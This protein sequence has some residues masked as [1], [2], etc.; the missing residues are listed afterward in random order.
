MRGM[1]TDTRHMLRGGVIVAAFA[2]F[3]LLTIALANAQ[4]PPESPT[5]TRLEPGINLVGW[6]GESTSV[7]QL[8]REVPQLEAIWA[9]DAELDDWIVASRDAPEGL[10]WLWRVSP[11]MGLR[12]AVGGEEPFLWERS[13]EPTRGLVELRTGWNLVAW[14]GADDAPLEQVA[15]GIGW[16]LREL[17][18]WNAANQRWTTWTSPER[19]AQL[20]AA[21]AADQGATDEEAEPVTVRRGEALWINVA[22]SVN[23]LQPTDILPRL[24]FPGGASDALQARVQEDLEAV[25]AFYGQ[26]YGIQANPDFAVYVAKDADALI[27]TYK[28]DGEEIDDAEAARIRARW[29][30]VDGWVDRDWDGERY[31]ARIVARRASWVGKSSTS[32]IARARHVLTHEYFHILQWQ[33]T[34]GRDGSE[35]LV[36]GTAE[37]AGSEREVLDGEQTLHTLREREQSKLSSRT[38][39]LR[40]AESD[41]NQW[42]YT[43]GWLAVD[44]LTT[45]AGD[46]S[47]VEFWR[48]SASTEI[49]PHGRWTST[50]DWRTAFQETFGVSVSS[51]YA[52][53]NVWQRQRAGANGSAASSVVGRPRWIR[54]RVTDESGVPAAGV[55]VNAVRVEG[56]IRVG[57]NQRAETDTDGAFAV[58]APEDGDYRLSVDINDDCASRYYYSDGSLLDEWNVYNAHPVKVAGSDLRNI[59][60]QLPPNVCIW[61][62]RGHIT[63][64]AGQPLAGVSVSA[65]ADVYG[66]ND[67]PVCTSGHTAPDGSFA[68]PA[69]AIGENRL[70]LDLTGDCRAYYHTGGVVTTKRGKASPISIIKTDSPRLQIH[71]P[72]GMCAYRINGTIAKSDGQPLTDVSI[73]ACREDAYCVER[74]TDAAGSFTITVPTEGRYRLNFRL[75]GC[76]V[77]LGSGPLTSNRNI[78]W[79]TVEGRDVQLWQRQVPDGWCSQQISGRLVGADGE[80]RARVSVSICQLAGSGC[81]TYRAGTT[82]ADGAFAVTVPVAGEYRLSFE[83]WS[84][85]VCRF[86]FGTNGLTDDQRQRSNVRVDRSGAH[87]GLLEIPAGMCE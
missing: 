60:I 42:E 14:S 43:L 36:E 20:I 61:F 82:D 32:G 48:R 63:T 10:G 28:D 3:L 62:I 24:I 55:F 27:Q 34:G 2:A 19:S 50:P 15:K 53:F 56:D 33:L 85:R 66:P 45:A 40:S 39:T 76:M 72:E 35:W 1:R 52:N 41:N 86:Y 9:W 29:D 80:P 46:G 16:S 37:W 21:S 8:F 65:C 75:D 38:P 13:T 22:R 59:E 7:S 71:V 51:F 57:W 84:I 83:F 78:A 18:R 12:L 79:L 31:I 11:G 49:G 74:D 6:T 30:R 70:H 77:Y 58:R 81:A 87:L 69:A 26:H 47:Y 25:L 54:G 67:S 64:G 5:A 44:R 68:V 4:E 23:W 73:A 17:R